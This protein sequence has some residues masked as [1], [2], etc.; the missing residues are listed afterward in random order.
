MSALATVQAKS[1]NGKF[2]SKIDFPIGHY[3]IA[4]ADIGDS[5]SLHTLFAKFF[6]PCWLNWNNIV[7]SKLV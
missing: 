2:T 4:D 7:L 6:D 3:T 5:K 1:F